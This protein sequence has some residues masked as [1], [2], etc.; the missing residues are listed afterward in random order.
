MRVI[1][2]RACPESGIC[3]ARVLLTTIR[4]KGYFVP[5]RHWPPTSGVLDT[6]LNGPL[7]PNLTGP[8]IVLRSVAASASRIDALSAPF[9]RLRTSA[10]TSSSAWEKPS[11]CVHCFPVPFSKASASSF[12]VRPSSDDLN[13]WFGVHHTSDD[14]PAPAGPSASTELGNSRAFPT[15]ATFGLKPRC[16]ACRQN[17]VKSGGIGTPVTISTLPS[18]NAE[19]CAEKSS[20]RSW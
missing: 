13:G 3:G 12:A 19:I 15:V 20:V 17:V 11:G 14:R 9:D 4:S 5:L 10:A 2:V 16:P 1:A 18:L 7:P 6:F 8:T